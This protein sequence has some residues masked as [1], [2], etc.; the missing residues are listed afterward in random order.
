MTTDDAPTTSEQNW[1]QRRPLWQKI[2]LVLLG[3]IIV[4][5][6]FGDP[7]QDTTDTTTVEAAPEETTTPTEADDTSAT[8]SAPDTTTPST[9]TTTIATTTTS[10]TTTTTTTPT[11]TT[12]E[13]AWTAFT[14]SGSGDD[15]IDFTIPGDEPAALHIEHSGG[16]NFAVVT[17]SAAGERL[18]LLVN[19]IG[20]Y[21]GTVPVNLYSGEEVAEIEITAGGAWTIEALPPADL[22]TLGDTAEGTGDAVL[23]NL[24]DSTRLSITHEG[25]SNFAVL[26]HGAR[27]ELLVNEIGSYS[28]T[29]RVDSG[30]VLLQI[31]ADGSWTIS[32]G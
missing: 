20:A 12:T 21:S 6:L 29:V 9:T 14:V 17:Y 22:P 2:G 11:T 25:E 32:G 18:D 8:T 31:T 15:V 28:G 10:S 30:S 1:W 24:S 4:A 13:P 19:E 23:I 16:S 27:R 7:E 26:S 3:L 5:G